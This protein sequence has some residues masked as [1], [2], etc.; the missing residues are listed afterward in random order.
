MGK[1]VANLLSF[2]IHSVLLVL[3]GIHNKTLFV[4]FFIIFHCMKKFKEIAIW[5]EK[6]FRD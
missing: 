3:F 5:L 1:E 2:F 6:T 4:Q